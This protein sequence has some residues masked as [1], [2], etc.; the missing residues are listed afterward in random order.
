MVQQELTVS[1]YSF[2]TDIQNYLYLLAK[3]YCNSK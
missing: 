3:K 2:D 1:D